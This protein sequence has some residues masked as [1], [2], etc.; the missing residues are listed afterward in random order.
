MQQQPTDAELDAS[1]P[2]SVLPTHT[3]FY[4]LQV[5]QAHARRLLPVVDG[6]GALV[7]LL[8]EEHLLE[9]WRADPLLPVGAVMAPHPPPR[10]PWLPGEGPE[11]RVV[12]AAQVLE[13]SGCEEGG[14]WSH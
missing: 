11:T 14:L 1:D 13:Q 5:M 4:A 9:A 10:E 12:T 7:G 2:V 6:D 3:L 8:T